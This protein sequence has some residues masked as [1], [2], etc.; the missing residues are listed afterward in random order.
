MEKKD[1][2]TGDIIVTRFGELGVILKENDRIL[3]QQSGADDLSDF[4]DDLRYELEEDPD[5]D[6]MEVYRDCTF[7]EI[8]IDEASFPIYVR[9]DEWRRPSKEERE[10]RMREIEKRNNELHAKRAAEFEEKRKHLIFIV[11]SNRTGQEVRPDDIDYFLR[12]I[13]L[14]PYRDKLTPQDEAIIRFHEAEEP[15]DRQII[16][17]PDCEEIVIVYDRAQEENAVREG[18]TKFIT[19]NIPEMNI[20]LHTRC[21]ACRMDENGTFKSLEDGDGE[22]YV[23]YF[24]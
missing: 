3:Y 18:K 7:L 12:G 15:V 9:D 20:K 13:C 5:S 14:S 22:K 16:R 1:L 17:V 11:D 4:S 8:D 10:A 6:I 24:R 19:C 23:K 2:M 21:F